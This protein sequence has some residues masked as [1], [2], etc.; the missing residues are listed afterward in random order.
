MAIVHVFASTSR[1]RS[2]E[3]MRTF[4]DQTY[5]EDGDGVPS[6]FMQEIGLS[7]YEPGCIEAIHVEH[8]MPLPELLAGV[9]YAEQWARQLDRSRSA[10]AA[11]CVFAPNV[12]EHPEGSSLDYCGAYEYTWNPSSGASS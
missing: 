6:G 1:F 7:R 11:I 10:D 12:V 3:E 2:F 9:S 8:P 5:T 4:I